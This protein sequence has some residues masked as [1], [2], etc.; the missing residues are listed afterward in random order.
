MKGAPDSLAKRPTK[1]TITRSPLRDDPS[2]QSEKRNQK[3]FRDQLKQTSSSFHFMITDLN[4]FLSRFFP[5]PDEPIRLQALPPKDGPG[6][7][8]DIVITR[9]DLEAKLD[10][11]QKINRTMNLYFRPN[12]GGRTDDQITRF[13][14]LFVE[15]D[16]AS[17]AK[18]HKAL[19]PFHPHVIVE[20]LKS[21]HAY[22]LL[23]PNDLTAGAWRFLQNELVARFKSD[24]TIVNPSRLMRLPFFAYLIFSPIN[25][26]TF[27]RLHLGEV[28]YDDHFPHID[29]L[30]DYEKVFGADSKSINRATVNDVMTS[31]I[32]T[33]DPNEDVSEGGRNAAL[34]RFTRSLCCKATDEGVVREAACEYNE[35][36]LQPP[37]EDDERDRAIERAISYGLKEY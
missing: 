19:A 28:A 12:S 1:L 5:D 16:N 15:K 25:G 13:N 37:L 33:L 29:G 21:V 31:G 34:F 23:E 10:Q 6:I 35:K 18:Q 22:W 17:F 9:S 30:P 24:K 4:L 7:P 14:A 26:G 20:T 27:K 8:Q 2:R 32:N 3:A 11:L 36:R